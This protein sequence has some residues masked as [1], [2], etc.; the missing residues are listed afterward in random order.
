MELH[1]V[2]FWRVVL[3]GTS[4]FSLIALIQLLRIIQAIGA[5]PLHSKWTI[6]LLLVA[7]E[8]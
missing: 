1:N 7:S 2:R 6:L 5:D 3:A 8:R 4:V